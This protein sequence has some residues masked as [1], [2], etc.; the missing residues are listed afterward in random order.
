MTVL[1][2]AIRISRVCP[3]IGTS[4]AE[5]E[6]QDSSKGKNAVGS[7]FWKWRREN[8]IH[9]WQSSVG[10]S[11]EFST[12]PV[13]RLM[14]QRKKDLILVKVGDTIWMG[15]PAEKQSRLSHCTPHLDRSLHEV[16]VDGRCLC[17]NR[18]QL[19]ST[20][21]SSPVS[22]TKNKEPHQAENERSSLV[23]SGFC[24]E[25]DNCQTPCSPV[26]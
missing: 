21:E 6:A 4:S 26:V 15:L 23:L 5:F 14:G 19:P 13:Q 24:K 11:E 25:P 8:E 16:Q 3:Q 20:L 1:N 18:C 2:L 7:Y 9:Y 10:P 22:S 12:S 17:R